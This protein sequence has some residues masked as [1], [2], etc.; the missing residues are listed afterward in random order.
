MMTVRM[1]RPRIAS[2]RSGPPVELVQDPRRRERQWLNH[3]LQDFDPVEA[4]RVA[5]ER[6]AQRRAEDSAG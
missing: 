5:G 6:G 3:L 2:W 1:S 4:L